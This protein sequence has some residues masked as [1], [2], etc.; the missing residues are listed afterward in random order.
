MEK[1]EGGVVVD[2]RALVVGAGLMGAAT[3]WELARRGC[4]VALVEAYDLGHTRGSSHGSSRIFRRAY[5]DPLYVALTGRARERWRELELELDTGAELLRV[6]GGLDFGAERDPV[7]RW[8][9]FLTKDGPE[10]Y[11]LPSGR[12]GGAASGPRWQQPDHT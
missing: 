10:L 8:P 7:A 6:T 5:R 2:V 12:D 11:G 1:N 4:P 9:V 3:A